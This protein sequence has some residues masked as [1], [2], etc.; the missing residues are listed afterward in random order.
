MNVPKDYIDFLSIYGRGHIF[1]ESA[2][3]PRIYDLRNSED[4]TRAEKLMDA[5]SDDLQESAPFYGY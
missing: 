3:S 4:L 5:M 2:L 1:E